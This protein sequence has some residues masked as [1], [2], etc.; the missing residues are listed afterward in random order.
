MSITLL[1]T[2]KK[3]QNKDLT[4]QP[5][6][7]WTVLNFDGVHDGHGYWKCRCQCG[8]IGSVR[9]AKLRENKSLS[10]GC[11]RDENNSRARRKSA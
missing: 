7:R 11:E 1:P 10:C 5:F 3:Y 2:P 8:N 4:G 9:G 6:G